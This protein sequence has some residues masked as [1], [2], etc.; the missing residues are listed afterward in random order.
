MDIPSLYSSYVLYNNV[1]FALT[2]A[3]YTVV[4]EKFL[5]KLGLVISCLI[6]NIDGFLQPL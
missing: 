5:L 1:A 4:K 2:F 3:F 6:Q